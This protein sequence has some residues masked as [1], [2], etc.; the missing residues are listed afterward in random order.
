MSAILRADGL[1]VRRGEHTMARGV[2]F[3]LPA[4]DAL[5]VIGPH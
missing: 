1:H 4:G 3:D 2:S 5:T